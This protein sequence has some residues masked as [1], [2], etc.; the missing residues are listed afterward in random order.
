MDSKNSEF[1]DYINSD[2]K[3]MYRLKHILNFNSIAWELYNQEAITF[4]LSFIY[5]NN[6]IIIIIIIIINI[7]KI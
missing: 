7:I 3:K 4:K 5:T 6:K 2:D 1:F